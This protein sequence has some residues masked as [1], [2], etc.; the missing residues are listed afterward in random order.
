MG[1]LPRVIGERG[2][3]CPFG[4]VELMPGDMLL[5]GPAVSEV[6]QSRGHDGIARK[7]A[8]HRRMASVLRDDGLGEV[9]EASALSIG[10]LASEDERLDCCPHGLVR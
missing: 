7:D 9:H 1:H 6:P 4:T 5:T 10:W 3:R 2:G 8:A